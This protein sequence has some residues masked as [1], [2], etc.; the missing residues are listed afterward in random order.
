[1][2]S[3]AVV[4]TTVVGMATTQLFRAFSRAVGV[5]IAMSSTAQLCQKLLHFK[6]VVVTKLRTKASRAVEATIRTCLENFRAGAATMLNY[7]APIKAATDITAVMGTTVEV[8][9]MRVRLQIHRYRRHKLP[10]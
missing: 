5:I 1:V 9:T 10:L 2:V 6:A 3:K 7:P 4:A 8:D